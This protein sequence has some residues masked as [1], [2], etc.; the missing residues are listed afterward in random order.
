M[1]NIHRRLSGMVGISFGVLLAPPLISLLISPLAGADPTTDLTGATG[2]VV[3]LG[4]YPFDGYTEML[5]FNDGTFA[6]DNYLTGTLDGSAFDLDTYFGPSG[7]GAFEVLL[8]DPG[9]FQL[10]VDDVGGSVSYIDNFFGIDFIPTDPGV[11][12]LG[13]L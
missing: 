7:S 1:N 9:V 13:G 3:T 2:Q 10:G 5:G 11:D 6:F 4:P 12:L 8:T